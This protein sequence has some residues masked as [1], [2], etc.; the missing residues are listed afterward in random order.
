MEWEYFSRLSYEVVHTCI[1]A[2]KLISNFIYFLCK[3][4]RLGE[5][6][7]C[8]YIDFIVYKQLLNQLNHFIKYTYTTEFIACSIE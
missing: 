2:I 8:P 7:N 3:S 5:V 4:L 1:H 6:N